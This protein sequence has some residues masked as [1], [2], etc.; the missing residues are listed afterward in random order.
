MPG[1]VPPQSRSARNLHAAPPKSAHA[2]PGPNPPSRKISATVNTDKKLLT[3][4]GR[5]PGS[6]SQSGLEG[7]RI[8]EEPVSNERRAKYPV[9]MPVGQSW[10]V[11]NIP[12]FPSSWQAMQSGF[13]IN[14]P[15]DK[16][17]QEADRVA[18]MV[19]RMSTVSAPIPVETYAS[20]GVQRACACGGTCERCKSRKHQGH[21]HYD[22]DPTI[23]NRVLQSSGQPLDAASRKYMEPRLGHDFSRIRIHTDS[24]AAE[25]AYAVRAKAYATGSHIV[26][27]AGKYSPHTSE[28]KRLIAHELTHVV[29]QA[30]GASSAIIQRDLDLSLLDRELTQGLAPTHTQGVIGHGSQPCPDPAPG[31]ESARPRHCQLTPAAED[32]QLPL[33]AIVFPRNQTTSSAVPSTIPPATTAPATGSGSAGQPPSSTSQATPQTS[34]PTATPARPPATAPAS[35]APRAVVIGGIHGNEGGAPGHVL[36]AERLQTELNAGLVREFDTIVVPVMNP[37]G[38]ADNQRTNRHGVDLN[39]NFPGLPGFPTG[40]RVVEQPE[41]AAVRRLIQTLHPSRILVLHAQGDVN[42]GG[43]YS[44]PVE[45]ESRE[46]ACRMALAMRGTTSGTAAVPGNLLD[47]G[48]CNSRYPDSA[49]VEQTTTHSSLGAWGSASQTDGGAGATVITHEI[50][51]SH[52]PLLEHGPGRSVDAMMLGIRE[53]LLDRRRSP[54]QADDLLARAVTTT[55]LSGQDTAADVHLRD[56]ISGIVDERFNDMN[57][58]YTGVWYPANHATVSGLPS[59]LT[60]VATT[61]VRDFTRQA[62]IVNGEFRRSLT[63]TSS[64]SDIQAAIVQVMQTRS[65]PGFSRHHWGTD[66][67]LVSAE[68][69][70]WETPHGRFIGLIPFL[71]EHA[72]RFGFFHPYTTGYSRS[73]AQPTQDGFPTPTARHYQE[74]AWHVSYWPIANVLQRLWLQTFTGAVLDNLIHD[75]AHAVHGAVPEAAMER[76]LRTIGL[77]SFQSNVA[78]SP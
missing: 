39:R 51:D 8:E 78:P 14:Q 9:S 35:P 46:L 62:D 64:D 30:K 47:Q 38:L 29:Q 73:G 67:D 22:V 65:M 41:T 61:G 37:G 43:V 72:F 48:V 57:A 68:R 60:I 44:D 25:S 6:G 32:P 34:P 49:A 1:F 36:I 42:K 7:Q 74:E 23:V 5:Q 13:T 55:F 53:F 31:H 18:E 33:Q 3:F 17:E 77:E 58:Y 21:G 70:D 76:V 50:P 2:T 27:G 63:A 52:T 4:Q 40:G 69:T 12:I 71:R 56:T 59:T 15:G 11:A 75:T 45:G 16:Y 24:Q 28:G 54:S 26:F 20:V 10:S 19:M 66:L